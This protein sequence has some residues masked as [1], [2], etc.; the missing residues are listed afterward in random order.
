MGLS[1]NTSKIK[2]E[3]LLGKTPRFEFPKTKNPILAIITH[4]GQPSIYIFLFILFFVFRIF[5]IKSNPIASDIV[6][7]VFFGFVFASLAWLFLK[8]KSFAYKFAGVGA[9]LAYILI[10]IFSYCKVR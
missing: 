2:D 7:M 9:I 3:G 5:N 10:I 6:F 4:F 1:Q 8:Q